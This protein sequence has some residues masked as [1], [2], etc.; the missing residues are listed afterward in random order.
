MQWPVDIRIPI[1]GG[2]GVK[3]KGCDLPRVTQL[4][5]PKPQDHSHPQETTVWIIKRKGAICKGGVGLSK[6]TKG[7]ARYSAPTKM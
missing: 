1:E 7:A 4:I 2:Q 5:V 6:E 3:E